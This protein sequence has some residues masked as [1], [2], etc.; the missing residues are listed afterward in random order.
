MSLGFL[1]S[2]AAV[3]VG[4]WSVTYRPGPE[5]VPVEVEESR[6]QRA[7]SSELPRGRRKRKQ[8]ADSR[9]Q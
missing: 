4:V 9:K 2:M 6:K 1:I 8:E 5:R 7:E 3:R